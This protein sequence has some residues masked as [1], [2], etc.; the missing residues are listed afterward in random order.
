MKSSNQSQASKELRRPS[1]SSSIGG[2]RRTSF[3]TNGGVRRRASRSSEPLPKLRSKDIPFI[4]EGIKIQKPLFKKY[5]EKKGQRKIK[6]IYDL[7]ELS[8]K[9]VD[10]FLKTFTQMYKAKNFFKFCAPLLINVNPGPAMTFDYLNLKNWIQEISQTEKKLRPHLY[11]FM[12]FVYQAMIKSKQDQVVNIVGQV[13][14]GKTFNLIHMIEYFCLNVSP[15]DF[16]IEIFDLIHKSIQVIH[17]LAS[18]YRD[19]NIESTSCGMLLKMGFDSDNLICDFDLEAKILDYSLPFSENGRSFS[20]FHALYAGAPI[21]VK[22]KFGL[23]MNSSSLNFFKKFVKSF[24]KDI[25]DKFSLNDLEIWNKFHS[26]LKFFEFSQ[27]EVY[28]IF[29]LVSFILNLGEVA[30]TEKTEGKYE[31]KKIITILD[32]LIAQKLSKA[33]N[34]DNEK[35]VE[36]FGKF[37]TTNDAKNYIICLMKRTYYILFEFIKM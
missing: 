23:P 10:Q 17:I 11:S 19:Q 12:L 8:T 25:L 4:V 35:F 31:K 37:K 29:D 14:S 5:L 13:G 7:S 33:L 28:E 1:M 6:D 21:H 34:I 36:N 3:S 20:I 9:T 18:I 15:K 16:D 2:K 24:N 30:L 27:E 26:L 22:K 32:G